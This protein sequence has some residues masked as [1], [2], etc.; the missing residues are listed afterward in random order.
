MPI[1][2]RSTA[3]IHLT[4]LLLAF[5]AAASAT[6]IVPLNTGYNH[7]VF[8]PYP[9][10]TTQPSGLNN[11]DHYWINIASYPTTPQPV[12]ASWVLQT[13]TA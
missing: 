2:T 11:R 8:A 3:W 9:P 7:Q 6:T 5:A 10:A 1:S 13:P 12:G 4:L